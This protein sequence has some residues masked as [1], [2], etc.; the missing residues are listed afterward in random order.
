MIYLF[1]ADGFE[2]IEA[3]TVVDI[4]RRADIDIKLISISGALTMT[5]AHN[6]VIEADE[7]FENIDFST[8]QMLILPGGMPGSNNLRDFKPLC[9]LILEY[10][11][12]NKYI[13]AICA[14]P[15]IFGQLNILEGKKATC[16][17]GFESELKGSILSTDNVVI[18]NNIITSRGP[19]TASDF[20][21]EIV[22][23]LTNN[24]I[25]TSVAKGMLF[26]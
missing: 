15:F 11:N 20:A 12:Q 18:N 16:Y 9:D 8:G 2:E 5:G 19:A 3:I 26:R 21:F 24:D 22:K 10:N 7:L 13:A 4:V 25:E 14:A 17:P 6:I 1:L 23:L